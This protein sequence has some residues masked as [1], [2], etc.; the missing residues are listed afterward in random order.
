MRTPPGPRAYP[1]ESRIRS[2]LCGSYARGCT[3]GLIQPDGADHGDMMF[4]HGLAYPRKTTFTICSRGV[5]YSNA[6]FTSGFRSSRFFVFLGFELKPRFVTS[7]PGCTVRV[8][9][10]W[11]LSALPAV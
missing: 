6:S 5:A 11:P 1:S 10:F 9:P 2:A 4:A 8:M 7:L 3:A